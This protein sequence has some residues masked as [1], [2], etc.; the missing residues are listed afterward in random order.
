MPEELQLADFTDAE[1]GR[2]GFLPE[3]QYQLDLEHLRTASTSLHN[4]INMFVFQ[5][6][7]GVHVRGSQ[8]MQ[9]AHALSKAGQ[10]RGQVNTS[11]EKPQFEYM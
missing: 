10:C 7:T 3:K 5:N 2:T 4:T 8:C 1:A 6:R 11:I 9:N